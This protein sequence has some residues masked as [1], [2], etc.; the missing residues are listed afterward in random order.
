MSNGL[1]D[2]I[3]LDERRT[4]LSP[5]PSLNVLSQP[6]APLTL[7]FDRQRFTEYVDPNV[8]E[9][10]LMEGFFGS[11]DAWKGEIMATMS[12]RNPVYLLDTNPN[13]YEGTSPTDVYY[14]QE[15]LYKEKDLEEF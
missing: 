8:I 1:A 6:V 12:I 5:N 9:E 15:L 11:P 4:R 3:Y 10:I 14:G 13:L 2:V 7:I